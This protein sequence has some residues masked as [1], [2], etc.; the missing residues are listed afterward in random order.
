[1]LVINNTAREMFFGN[2]DPLGQR[3]AF[4]GTAR[5][6][7]GVVA[8]E[9]IHGLEDE[10][11]PATYVPYGQRPLADVLLVRTSGD[12]S[13]AAADIR[14]MVRE[15]DPALALFGVEPLDDTVSESLRARQFAALL[16]GAFA[17]LTLVLAALGLYGMLSHGVAQ[18]SGE[19]GIRLALGAQPSSVRRLII[20]QG[21]VLVTVGLTAG[22][23]GALLLGRLLTALLFGTAPTDIVT[24]VAT[25]V[26]LLLTAVLASYLPARRASRVAPASA[27]RAS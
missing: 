23:G 2:R 20:G 24:F 5:T 27:L 15:I 1:V 12:P 9:K 13:N 22:I 16:L 18:R 26:V 17:L 6:I 14:A 19:I 7:V 8:D 4:W 11:P 3:I 25:S 10:S 21:L